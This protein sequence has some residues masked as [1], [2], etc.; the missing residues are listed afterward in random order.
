MA[1]LRLRQMKK[2]RVLLKE[3]KMV[4]GGKTATS[5]SNCQRSR[6]CWPCSTRSWLLTCPLGPTERAPSSRQ[7]TGHMSTKWPSLE[8]KASLM[9]ITSQRWPSSAKSQSAKWGSHRPAIKNGLLRQGMYATRVSIFAAFP[10]TGCNRNYRNWSR[11]H[12][13]SWILNLKWMSPLFSKN[14]VKGITK[15]RIALRPSLHS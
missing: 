6:Q 5:K 2:W 1:L 12:P 8:R 15:R 11:C 7:P 3:V 14:K 9:W 10:T 4:R 13:K